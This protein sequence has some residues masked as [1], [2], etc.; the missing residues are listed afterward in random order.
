MAGALLV[1]DGDE[2]SGLPRHPSFFLF[3]CTTAMYY[4]LTPV[5]QN[6]PHFAGVYFLH[7]LINIGLF[8]QELKKIGFLL[9]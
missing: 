3:L 1:V 5:I 7:L 8:L 4:F 9:R 6:G 2:V